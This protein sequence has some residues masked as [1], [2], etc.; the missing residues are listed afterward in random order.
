ML[1][2]EKG[3]VSDQQTSAGKC[4]AFNVNEAD[5]NQPQTLRPRPVFTNYWI[6]V[7]NL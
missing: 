4:L 1:D 3:D 7:G 2:K 5:T 6:F